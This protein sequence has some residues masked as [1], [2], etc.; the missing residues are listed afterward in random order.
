MQSKKPSRI[1]R[2]DLVPLGS[3][4]TPAN[5]KR[6]MERSAN[7]TIPA[8]LELL[9]S[10]MWV[11]ETWHTLLQ[12]ET[13]VTRDRIRSWRPFKWPV[14]AFCMSAAALVAPSS[15]VARVDLIPSRFPAM[16]RETPNILPESCN[17]L[18]YTARDCSCGKPMS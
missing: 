15:L 6:V 1:Q 5:L 18:K 2:L 9:T 17:S 3:N 10:E 8:Q 13:S 11:D 7:Q 16:A 14:T 12:E 4:K